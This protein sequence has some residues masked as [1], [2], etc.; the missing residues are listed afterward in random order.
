MFFGN[1]SITT[2]GTIRVSHTA[3][4]GSSSV[5]FSDNGIP[6][7]VR[8]NSFWTVATG[9]GLATATNFSVRTEGTGFGTVGD[10]AHLRLTRVGDAAVGTPGTNAGSA[11]NPQVNRTAIPLANLTNNFYWG[12]ID[13]TNTP[14]PVELISFTAALKFDIVELKWSTASELNNDH[15]TIERSTDLE[16]FEVV[17]TI[18]GNGTTNVIHHYNTLDPSPVYGRS[19]YRL[20]QTD[21]DGKYSYSDVRVI[22]YEGPKFSSLRAYPNPLS[23]SVISLLLLQDLKIKPRFP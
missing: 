22:D 16:N 12:S 10:P 20:K 14:L 7:Q 23:G 11:T 15:F 19:Y 1:T 3:V 5:V 21:F 6:V 2:G 4:N 17:A 13:A 9:N 18:P 8:S